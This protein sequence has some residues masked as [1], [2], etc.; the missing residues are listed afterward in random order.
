MA[1]TYRL[2]GGP[3]SGRVLA[4]GGC[5]LLGLLAGGHAGLERG[6]GRGHAP[7]ADRTG[8]FVDPPAGW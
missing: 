7:T 5:P 4:D 6:T 2:R 8:G 3:A 1:A